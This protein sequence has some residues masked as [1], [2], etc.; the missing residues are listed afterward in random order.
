M[1]PMISRAAMRLLR[2]KRRATATA[3]IG[4]TLSRRNGGGGRPA[5]R[6]LPEILR[7]PRPAG[8]WGRHA[9]SPI[10]TTDMALW[11]GGLCKKPEHLSEGDFDL[12]MTTLD[13]VLLEEAH[14]CVR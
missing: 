5:K 2:G 12:T 10:G 13:D 6:R 11:I 8:H 9:G 14:I 4:A 1:I 7:R 3:L